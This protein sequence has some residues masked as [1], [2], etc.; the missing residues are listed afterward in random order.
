LVKIWTLWNNNELN[1]WFNGQKI[2][3]LNNM[4]MLDPSWIVHIHRHWLL[5]VI[6]WCEHFVA[7]KHLLKII[8]EMIS[9]NILKNLGLMD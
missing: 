2:Y 9:L 8:G 7:F 4:V 1:I 6:S 5:Q 3:A